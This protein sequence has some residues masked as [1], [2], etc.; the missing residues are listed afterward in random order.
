VALATLSLCALLSVI[1]VA[2]FMRASVP[3]V[4]EKWNI[5]PAIAAGPFITVSNDIIGL[6]IYLSMANLYLSHFH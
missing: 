2:A 5:D 1:L 3:L 4:L 6:V